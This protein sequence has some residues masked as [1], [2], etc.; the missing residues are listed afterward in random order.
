MSYLDNLRIKNLRGLR[1]TGEIHLKPINILVGK[2]SSG[3]STFARFF[4]L[5]K[6]SLLSK[7]RDPL[8]WWGELVDFGS[9]SDAVG[10]YREDRSSERVK[11]NDIE[12]EIGLNIKK[13]ASYF[14]QKVKSKNVSYGFRVGGGEGDSSLISYFRVVYEGNK[15]EAFVRPDRFV[16]KIVV[17]GDVIFDLNAGQDGFYF[18]IDEASIFPRLIPCSAGGA[19]GS[20]KV[21]TDGAF[22][23]LLGKQVSEQVETTLMMAINYAVMMEWDFSARDLRRIANDLPE[24]YAV[25]GLDLKRLTDV[26]IFI[27]AVPY[28]MKELST[29]AREIFINSTY[30]EPLRAAANRYYRRQNLSTTEI[31]SRGENIAM[32]LS[33]HPRIKEFNDWVAKVMG[34]KFRV[35]E[36]G[37]HISISVEEIGVGVSENIADMGFGFSQLLP[38]LAQVWIASASGY[39]DVDEGKLVVIEQP[40]LHLHPAYQDKIADIFVAT[41][42]AS[43]D[44]TMKIVAE[45]HS[46]HLVN[47][48]GLLIA[49][50]KLSKDDVQILVFDFDKNTLSTELSIAEFNDRGGLVNWPHG[51]FE[52]E[53]QL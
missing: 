15:F 6:Q 53:F 32:F 22:I 3:K 7:P 46:P 49:K 2:N 41:I 50:K 18:F 35:E 43:V 10:A 14:K 40:E 27:L 19:D 31:D 48:L 47:K 17:N 52:P 39:K 11:S 30:V 24:P 16:E 42:E 44:K 5:V 51:F 36:G 20:M 26:Q 4:P 38:I 8:L 37:G 25:P 45:T 1:D 23:R 29:A 33:S 28:I 34:F 9:F 13:R 12:F 21:L